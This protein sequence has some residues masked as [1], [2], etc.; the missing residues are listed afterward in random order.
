MLGSKSLST[1]RLR[2]GLGAARRESRGAFTLI[3]ILIVIS[4]ISLLASLVVVGILH[5][6]PPALTAVAQ[7][8]VGSLALAVEY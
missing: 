8:Q 4:I 5:S 7:T 1:R 6:R 3:E 2:P